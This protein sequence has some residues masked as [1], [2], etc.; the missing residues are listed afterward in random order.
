MSK[1]DD[2]LRG[3]LASEKAFFPGGRQIHATTEEGPSEMT[4][5]VIDKRYTYLYQF[6]PN[7]FYFEQWEVGITPE[8]ERLEMGEETMMWLSRRALREFAQKI[9]ELLP[10]EATS[11]S[12]A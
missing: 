5:S 3:K 1:E 12:T 10:P 6:D 11:P 2:D 7:K 9:L 8:G 4:P